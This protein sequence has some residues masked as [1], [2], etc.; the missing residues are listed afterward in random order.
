[1]PPRAAAPP[2]IAPATDPVLRTINMTTSVPG[3]VFSLNGGSQDPYG[4][5]VTTPTPASPLVFNARG[6]PNAAGSF[7]LA[8]IDGANTF[9][10]SVTGAGRTRIWRKSGGGWR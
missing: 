3:V 9:A 2:A 6:L 5:T 7:F 4:G 10:V 1:M 8:S